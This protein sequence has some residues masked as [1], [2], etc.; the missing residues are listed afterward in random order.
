MRSH[1]KSTC[2]ERVVVITQRHRSKNRSPCRQLSQG[3]D[4]TTGVEEGKVIS[5]CS[6]TIRL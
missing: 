3:A 6:S 5:V 1:E 4:K 2:F